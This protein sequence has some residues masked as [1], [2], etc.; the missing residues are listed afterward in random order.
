MLTQKLTGRVCKRGRTCSSQ[1]ATSAV[2]VTWLE[3]KGC[4]CA[5]LG[6]RLAPSVRLAVCFLLPLIRLSRPFT[7]AGFLQRPQPPPAFHA[8][9]GPPCPCGHTTAVSHTAPRARRRVPE[10]SEGLHRVH[11]SHCFSHSL[12]HKPALLLPEA[13]T[14]HYASQQLASWGSLHPYD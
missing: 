13:Y 2:E 12:W 8:V 7:W 14:S 9:P 5:R 3:E 1:G 6:L 10:A 4:L 11:S